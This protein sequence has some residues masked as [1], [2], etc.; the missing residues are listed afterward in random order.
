MYKHEVE[1]E[2]ELFTHIDFLPVCGNCKTRLIGKINATSD[3]QIWNITPFKCPV[4][5]TIFESVRMTT[6][7]P[8]DGYDGEGSNN[9]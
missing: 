3:G 9:I 2:E 6:T 4:C 8:F 7:L 1:I 5:N